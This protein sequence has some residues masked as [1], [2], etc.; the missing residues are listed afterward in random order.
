MEPFIVYV[1]TDEAGRITAVSSS[2]F[3]KDPTGWTEVDRGFLR[4]HMH[5]QGNYLEKGLR[6]ERGLFNYKLVD[7][8]PVERTAGEMDPEYIPPVVMPSLEERLALIENIIHKFTE[9][10][11]LK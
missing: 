2:Q 5:A 7:G 11:G 8:K 4:K 3:L 1:K 10:F 9:R 6:D